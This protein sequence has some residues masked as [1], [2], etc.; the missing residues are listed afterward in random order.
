[1]VV[2]LHYPLRHIP[3][4]FPMAHKRLADTLHH[5]SSGMV[6]LHPTWHGSACLVAAHVH[7]SACDWVPEQSPCETSRAH[8]LAQAELAQV[9][10]ASALGAV[11]DVTGA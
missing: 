1:M 3:H 9:G 8:R 10:V 7:M 4:L 2:V 6:L 11:H 5:S